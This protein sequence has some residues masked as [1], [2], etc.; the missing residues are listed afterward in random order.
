MEFLTPTEAEGSSGMSESDTYV[1]LPALSPID[2]SASVPSRIVDL[3]EYLAV[4]RDR[5]VLV[6]LSWEEKSSEENQVHV[7][8]AQTD[9]RATTRVTVRTWTTASYGTETTWRP[10]WD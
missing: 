1:T 10:G 5:L 3:S 9:N 2:L 4:A 7:P 6:N 8:W